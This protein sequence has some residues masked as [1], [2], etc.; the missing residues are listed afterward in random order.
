MTT[1]RTSNAKASE[2]IQDRIAFTGNNFYGVVTSP[3]TG[4]DYSPYGRLD[5]HLILQLNTEFPDYIVY[6]YGTPIAWFG[7]FGWTIPNVK[8]SVTTSKH[9]NYVRRSLS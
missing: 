3:A 9:Q 5:T 8:Y 7:R 2:F 1:T 4:T 6:S